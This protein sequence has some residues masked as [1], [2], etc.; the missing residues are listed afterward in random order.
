MKGKVALFLRVWL[1][2]LGLYYIVDEILEGNPLPI[3][4][5]VIA[6]LIIKIREKQ[7]NK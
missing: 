4:A 2:L 5:V 3:I 1:A 7:K 6:I